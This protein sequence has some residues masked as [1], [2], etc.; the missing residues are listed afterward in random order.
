[1]QQIN[2][3]RLTVAVLLVLLL[4]IFAFPAFASD[5]NTGMADPAALI[6]AFDR[7]VA[8]GGAPVQVIPLAS[9]RGLVSEPCRRSLRTP[10]NTLSHPH[11]R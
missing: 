7:F 4:A 2:L 5:A 9:L 1:M 6:K 8:G 3:R 11:C 10:E